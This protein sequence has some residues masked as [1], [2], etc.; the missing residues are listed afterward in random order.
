MVAF[1]IADQIDDCDWRYT[2]AVRE[3]CDVVELRLQRHIDNI[4]AGARI[5]PLLS[6]SI[7]STYRGRVRYLHLSRG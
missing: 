3:V 4:M 2:D 1:P 6:I 7:L 5:Q